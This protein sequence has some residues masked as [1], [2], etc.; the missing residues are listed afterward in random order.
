MEDRPILVATDGNAHADTA[1]IAAAFIAGRVGG[2]VR[3]F[4]IVEGA[5]PACREW[6]NTS[7]RLHGPHEPRPRC[8]T[9]ERISGEREA[10]CAMIK[11]QVALTVGDAANW[12]VTVHDGPL[13]ET[14]RDLVTRTHARLMVIGQCRQRTVDVHADADRATDVLMQCGV[15]V[16]I[17]APTLR[18]IARRVVA[19]IDFSEASIRA[20]QVVSRICAADARMYLV[21]VI[22]Y[23]STREMEARRRELL[24]VERMLNERSGVRLESIMLVG[25]NAA[26]E[27]LNFADGIQ[28]DVIACGS[29]DSRAISSQDPSSPA[30]D[31]VTQDLIRQA[32]CSLLIAPALTDL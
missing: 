32:S 2:N 1:L 25:D 4:S 17:A 21:H 22:P 9:Q 23:A 27:T 12:P 30:A 5:S 11:G 16:Y 29:P 15:P 24:S 7:G 6:D 10:R 28:A 31:H 18:G 26:G 19:A 3:V 20:A 14:S 8:R 13:G